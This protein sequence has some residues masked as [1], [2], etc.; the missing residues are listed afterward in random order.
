MF[1]PG[2]GGLADWWHDISYVNFNNAGS[3]VH[4]WYRMSQ[5][6]GQLQALNRSDKIN[7]CVEAARTAPSGALTVPPGAIRYIVTSPGI[8]AFGW[9]GGAFMAFDFEVGLAVHEGGH[10]IGLNHTFSNNPDYRNVDWAAI[11]EYDDPWDAMSWANSYVATTPFGAAPAALVAPHLDRM[12]W[13]PRSRIAVHAANGAS[14]AIYTLAATNHPEASGALLVRV[15][16]A[17]D[18]L[19]RYY[20]IEF[21]RKDR[22]S[23]GIPADTVLIHEVKRN[24]DAA[25]VPVGEQIAWLQR[26][27]ARADKAPAQ[28]LD[29]NGV[30]IRV[31][32]IN[33][34][35]N[36]ATVSVRS[37]MAARCLMGFVWREAQ[38]G[39][40]VC[41]PP[42]ERA[43][44]R[45]ENAEAASRREPGGGAYGPN[46]CRSGFVWR[47]AFDGD[48]VCVPP[49]SRTRARASNAQAGARANP[50]R[51]AYGPNTCQSGFVWREADDVDWVCVSP[52]A[53]QQARDD[54]AL[55][56][57]RRQPGGGAYGPNTCDSGFVWR[58]A[59]PDDV[60]CVPPA[61]RAAARADNAAAPTRLMI[62]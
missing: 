2:N 24:R 54:N 5:T 60:V 30:Q 16:F 56:S 7:A 37:E 35:T 21:I 14:E 19:F 20:T 26:D 52:A 15:P 8:D 1:T 31:L 43:E 34:A 33:P 46:T 23:A 6:T 12:G 53:R 28:A 22:W 57:S 11:G 18:D 50:A 29:A 39:D 17:P 27:L 55:A 48:A 58:E 10:G 41:V 62:P 4:G 47:E 32:S 38:P 49:A 25:G 44:T 51:I 59:F 36:Q 3:E 42:A 13:L 45:Q 9:N 61:S 40:L